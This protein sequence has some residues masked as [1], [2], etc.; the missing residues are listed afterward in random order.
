MSPLRRILTLEITDLQIYELSVLR[1]NWWQSLYLLSFQISNRISLHKMCWLGQQNGPTVKTKSCR[2]MFNKMEND[3]FGRSTFPLG[4]AFQTL[5]FRNTQPKTLC[6]NFFKK[7]VNSFK[8]YGGL[9]LIIYVSAIN[10]L[11][12][13]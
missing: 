13:L 1:N 11:C 12:S 2:K 6:W 7:L 3:F 5:H 10:T 4:C 9:F 8:P